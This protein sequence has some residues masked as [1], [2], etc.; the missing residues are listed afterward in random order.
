MNILIVSATT[1]EILPLAE[2]KSLSLK[3]NILIETKYKT[4][5]LDVLV[6]G[7]GMVNTAFALGKQFQKKKYDIALNV[8]VC[9]AFSRNMEIGEVYHVTQDYFSELGA[10]DGE[11]YLTAKEIGLDAEIEIVNESKIKN[12]VLDEL[13]KV[14]GI[15]VNTVHGHEPSI[16]KVFNRFHPNVESMEGAA[17]LMACKNENIPCAQIRSVSNYVEKRNKDNWNMPL[18]IQYLNKKLIEILDNF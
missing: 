4:Y 16:E 12:A 11:K 7:V 3:S 15:T 14:F 6:T 13:P 1:Q 2:K 5:S 18:A 10:E 8:G 9:G 17:F